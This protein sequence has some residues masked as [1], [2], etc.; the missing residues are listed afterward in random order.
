MQSPKAGTCLSVQRTART[1]GNLSFYL[2]EIESL[3]SFEQRA[4]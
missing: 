2:S 3:E 1:Y 4:T